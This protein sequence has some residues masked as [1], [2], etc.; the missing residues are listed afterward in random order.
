MK[1]NFDHLFLDN[2][3]KPVKFGQKPAVFKDLAVSA[4]LHPV[5]EKEPPAKEKIHRFD[6]A[7]RIQNFGSSAE[8]NEGDLGMLKIVMGEY[9]PLVVGPAMYL[10]E[11]KQ[12]PAF[13]IVRPEAE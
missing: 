6:L 9:H 1:V 3:G 4:L 13:N 7:V 11:G 2:F 5:G 10:L 8:L 12:I